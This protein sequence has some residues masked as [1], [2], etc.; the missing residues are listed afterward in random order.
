MLEEGGP[1]VEKGRR[2]PQTLEC[3]DAKGERQGAENRE[4]RWVWEAGVS[5]CG[6]LGLDVTLSSLGQLSYHWVQGGKICDNTSLIKTTR[7]QGR[8]FCTQ[9][10]LFPRPPCKLL[11]FLLKTWAVHCFMN[12]LNP[13]KSQQ[14]QIMSLKNIYW[15]S[16]RSL[17]PEPGMAATLHTVSAEWAL[18]D[19]RNYTPVK[20]TQLCFQSAD[21]IFPIRNS[22]WSFNIATGLPPC[23]ERHEVYVAVFCDQRESCLV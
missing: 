16:P 14:R 10:C 17:P 6:G 23:T 22:F 20:A 2:N 5:G 11:D 8:C 1:G 7:T 19:R 4:Q 15:T 9:L 18:T 3:L 21:S 13:S 12:L